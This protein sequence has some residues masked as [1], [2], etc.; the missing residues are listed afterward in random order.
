MTVQQHW[1]ANNNH[2]EVTKLLL[3]Y[4]ANV[5]SMSDTSQTPL[6]LAEKVG[7]TEIIELLKSYNAKH[8]TDLVGAKRFSS[9]EP[10]TLI[11]LLGNYNAKHRTD[12]PDTK[13]FFDTSYH[14]TTGELVDDDHSETVELLSGTG[15]GKSP[16]HDG[17]EVGEQSCGGAELDEVSENLSGKGVGS[18]RHTVTDRLES[19]IDTIRAQS[20]WKRM[21]ARLTSRQRRKIYFLW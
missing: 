19:G 21:W 2:Y 12:F 20:G 7:R 6:D 5:N 14:K 10:G 17:S 8:G 3:E 13:R 1:A 16:A 11:E 15:S 9:G 18:L 4:E